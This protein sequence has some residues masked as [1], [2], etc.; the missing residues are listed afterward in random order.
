MLIG[1]HS[2]SGL[3]ASLLSERAVNCISPA[4]GKCRVTVI[5]LSLYQT[6]LGCRIKRR[7]CLKERILDDTGMETCLRGLDTDFPPLGSRGGYARS[8]IYSCHMFLKYIHGKQTKRL[9][10]MGE[11]S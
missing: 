7:V 11:G 2:E 4:L 10:G 1:L 8:F 3:Q 5:W 6:G 9:L